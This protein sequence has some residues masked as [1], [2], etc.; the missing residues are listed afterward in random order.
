MTTRPSSTEHSGGVGLYA[1]P[2]RTC[3]RF[4]THKTITSMI[5]FAQIRPHRPFLVAECGR[6]SRSFV[7]AALRVS[8]PPPTEKR[9]T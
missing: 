8:L 6:T 1:V 7:L 2:D 9:V 3:S 5:K 4:L